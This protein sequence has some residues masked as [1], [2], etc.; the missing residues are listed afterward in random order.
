MDKNGNTPLHHASA[1]DNFHIV[2]HLLNEGANVNLQNL[3]EKKSSLHFAAEKGH[4]DVVRLLLEQKADVNV[5]DKDGNTPLHFAAVG[6]HVDVVRAL[7]E[8]WI[9]AN[10]SR[11]LVRASGHYCR[12]GKRKRI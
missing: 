5:Q 12:S 7:L 8:P 9:L 2:R 4:L 6:G 11:L 3:D 10:Y 1:N